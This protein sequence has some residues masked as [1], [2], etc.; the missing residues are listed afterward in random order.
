MENK[1][2]ATTK[3]GV[4][5]EDIKTGDILYEFEY[6]TCIKTEVI[7]EPERSEDG[8][9]TWKGFSEGAG[10]INYLVT[11]GLTHYGPNLYDYMAYQ[12]CRVL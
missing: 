12:G 10:E 4:I 8:Q 2:K 3:G 1:H 5:L 6:G 11:E 7:T 9:W